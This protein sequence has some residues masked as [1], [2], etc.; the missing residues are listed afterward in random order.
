MNSRSSILIIED[1]VAIQNVLL[2]SI[3]SETYFI[4]SAYSASEGIS[5]V[6]SCSPDAILLDLGLPGEDG[7]SVIRAVREWSNVPIIVLSARTQEVEKVKA[8]DLGANDYVTKP[9]GIDELLARIRACMRTAQSN[10]TGDDS[11]Y[12]VGELKIDIASHLATKSGIDLDLT[13]KEFRL[14]ALLMKNAGKVLTHKALLTAVWGENYADQ[15]QYLRV[16]MKQLRE[17]IENNPARP[18]T[19]L[20]EIG[21]G[22]RLNADE[23]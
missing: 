6:A 17:K 21:V 22:Y 8:L 3:P 20:T 9:F 2:A 12:C 16:F 7:F 5:L 11:C 18:T 10:S 13:P 15:V 1:E 14:L 4:Y 23:K 19:I